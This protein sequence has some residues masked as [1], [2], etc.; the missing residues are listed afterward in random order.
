MS[1]S[2]ALAWSQ[3]GDFE[4]IIISWEE[5]GNGKLKKISKK[6]VDKLQ[7][8]KLLKTSPTT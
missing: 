3:I 7:Q 1:S 8:Q 2:P 4:L 5:G 6:I